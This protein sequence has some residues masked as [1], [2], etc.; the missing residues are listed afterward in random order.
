MSWLEPSS[1][2][3]WFNCLELFLT[4]GTGADPLAHLTVQ[5]EFAKLSHSS[6]ERDLRGVILVQ[7]DLAWLVQDVL[8]DQMLRWRLVCGVKHAVLADISVLR[9]HQLL[10]TVERIDFF[11]LVKN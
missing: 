1:Y 3:S 10:V 5:D 6:C 4:H 8:W 9:S 2:G 7:V 11:K